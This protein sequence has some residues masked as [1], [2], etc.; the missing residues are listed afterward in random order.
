MEDAQEPELD[1]LESRERRLWELRLLNNHYA[2]AR[3]AS[4]P[5]RHLMVD[6][7]SEMLDMAFREGRYAT[8]Y[9][10][11]AHSALNLW[12]RSTSQRERDELKLQQQT[13]LGLLLREQRRDVPHLSPHSADYLCFSSLKIVTH[14]MALVQTLPLD[15]WEPPLEFL[16]M[17]RGA[18]AVFRAAF[19]MVNAQDNNLHQFLKSP[20]IMHETIECD[21]STLDWLIEHPAGADSAAALADT[22]LDDAET[23]AVYDKAL[24]YT[25]SVQNAIK[26]GEPEFAVCR[27]LGGFAFWVPM[28]FSQ[29]LAARRPRAMVIL[30]HFMSL[31]INYEDFWIIGKAGERQIRGIHKTLPLEWNYKLDSLFAKFKTAGQR[32]KPT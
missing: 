28:E 5:G 22:E 21:H 12:T 15:P 6:W 23:K 9:G 7:E 27:R 29:F 8:L 30:A 11:L 26:E 2:M 3:A 13:Y 17:G 24:S 16:Q 25:C 19:A 14:S 18:G 10:M 31:W 1:P 20:R 32:G 4:G